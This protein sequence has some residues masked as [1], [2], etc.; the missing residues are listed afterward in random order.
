M[1]HRNVIAQLHD[2]EHR[3]VITQLR[4]QLH[5]M[6]HRYVIA[7]LREQLH[8]MEQEKQ[9]QYPTAA[10]TAALPRAQKDMFENIVFCCSAHRKWSVA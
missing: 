3:Y 1:K 9:V 4:E 8:G 2:M 6:E 5:S 7:Q 10:R